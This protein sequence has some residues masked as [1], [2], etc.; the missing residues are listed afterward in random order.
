M[1]ESGERRQF[2]YTAVL[3]EGFSSLLQDAPGKMISHDDLL[4]LTFQRGRVLLQ[5][6]AGA[7]KSTFLQRIAQQSESQTRRTRQ[8]RAPDLTRSAETKFDADV[9]EI[10]LRQEFIDDPRA[11][12]LIVDGL[13]EV[14]AS[15]AQHL[16]EGIEQLTQAESGCAVLVSDR[17]RRRSINLNRWALISLS[18]VMQDEV[19]SI[20]KDSDFVSRRPWARL[21]LYLGLAAEGVRGNSQ[22]AVLEHYIS[23][24]LGSDSEAV[25]ELSE[26]AY[27]WWRYRPS[28]VI[29]SNWLRMRLGSEL[30]N[31]ALH[32]ERPLLRSPDQDSIEFFH[33]L[34]HGL[35][36]A[37]AI[38]GLA[39]VW[40]RHAF[41]TLTLHGSTFDALGLLLA[42]VDDDK[43]D[44]L[45]REVDAWNFYAASY[46]L[47]EDLSGD[48]RVSPALRS[49]L[50]LTLAIRRFGPISST[51]VQVEDAL[52][53]HG[54]TL[55]SQLLLASDLSEIAAIARGLSF[56][57]TWWS[58]WLDSLVHL[59]MEPIQ[60]KDVLAVGSS[61]SLLGWMA[62][63]ILAVKGMASGQWEVVRDLALKSADDSIRWRY[64]HA[65]SGASDWASIESCLHAFKEDRARWVRYG[66]LR[67]YLSI[68]SRLP[69]ASDRSEA[70][71]RLAQDARIIVSD[72]KWTREVERSAQLIKVPYGW[73]NDVGI[74]VEQLWAL[75]K[76]VD[77]Q[78]RWRR[79]S[80]RLRTLASPA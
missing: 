33:I 56:E 64:I 12:L 39:D 43:V 77:E 48:N 76:S 11:L 17:P 30:I 62:A 69:D 78:D 6:K 80:A 5:A 21:P 70:F 4:D 1:S 71:N 50:L 47:I 38:R 20:I 63:N 29:D 28:S 54:G 66:A 40:S 31:R 45:V 10:S 8:L 68:A 51:V 18:T 36:A 37:R 42:Q 65:L 73:S 35:C 59:I 7:G 60:D 9:A 53:M 57:S 55:S 16:L 79:L 19:D 67:S 46:L 72:P 3:H 32:S 27:E 26:A 75:S 22:L 61:D 74:L 52:Q 41:E 34:L 24:A 13:D 23:L 15:D 25:D 2:K 44:T 58:S 14:A 49:A